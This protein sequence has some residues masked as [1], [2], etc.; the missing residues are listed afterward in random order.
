MDK[1]AQL[2]AI[3]RQVDTRQRD[4]GEAKA[5]VLSQVFD[6]DIDDAWEAC[7]RADRI[8]EWFLPITGELEL[9]GTYQLEG[10]AGGTI[11]ACDEPNAFAATWEFNGQVSWIEVRLRRVDG[12]QTRFELVHLAPD[13]DH[14]T[15]FGPGAAGV[16][17]DM[18]M[19]GLAEYLATG[20]APDKE[21]AM[22]WMASEDGKA[23][24]AQSSRRW[25]EAHIASGA[26][27]DAA[28]K[29]AERTVAIYTGG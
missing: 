23:Y 3:D 6:T 11:E 26:D 22:A 5:I 2:D 9:G 13:D 14:W 25:R 24:I 1:Q 12:D 28:R 21:A 17:W 27:A 8:A 7:T 18:A 4:E 16:G 20:E 29:A 15:Q 19:G 10:N